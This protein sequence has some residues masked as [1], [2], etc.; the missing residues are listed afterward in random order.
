MSDFRQEMSAFNV[1]KRTGFLIQESDLGQ[2]P[3]E[4]V[5]FEQ[6]ALE[7]P[8]L[9]ERREIERRVKELQEPSAT[10]MSHAAAQRVKVVLGTLIQGYVWEPVVAGRGQP[11]TLVPRQ[12]ARPLV[13]VARLLDEP[14]IFSYADLVL[15]D[16][17]L[18]DSASGTSWRNISKRYLFTGEQEEVGFTAL[19]VEYEAATGLAIVHGLT[20]IR[21]AEAGDLPT[22]E[23]ALIA[24]GAS[25]GQMGTQFG[26]LHDAISVGF[27][28]DRLRV[29]LQ[30]WRNIVPMVYE[31][32][33]VAAHE[34]R[35]ET[36]A[37]S[38]A[39]P[40]IDA[41]LGVLRAQSG[42]RDPDLRSS[43][44]AEYHDFRAYRPRLHRALV[45][46]V[47]R[48]G[49]VREVVVEVANG[50]LSNA[51]NACLMA[52]RDARVAHLRAV[53]AYLA[54]A[55]VAVPETI[56]TGGTSYAIYLRALIDATGS[57]V[58]V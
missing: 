30:G 40:F 10:P 46:H 12:L 41:T 49:R 37:Q 4:F 34:L 54:Q 18:R 3:R 57:S 45:A 8:T 51:Y 33:N 50:S 16:W 55:G 31:G 26:Q 29:F 1:A 52:V 27:F 56:G 15:R 48:V 53:G 44:V 32:T 6:M 22:L 39:I 43:A 13:E 14:P 20:A 11:R 28:R 58:V 2:V 24:L 25:M 38:S 36:G 35:G 7:L 5:A 19:H 21:A 42:P 23:Q 9:I 47:E 17:T